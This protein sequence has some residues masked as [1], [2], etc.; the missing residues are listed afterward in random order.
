MRPR[1]SRGSLQPFEHF[2]RLGLDVHLQHLRRFHD[3]HE[4]VVVRCD[5]STDLDRLGHE[6]VREFIPD[7]VGRHRF[8]RGRDAGVEC[9]VQEGL[10]EFTV[11][12]RCHGP[13]TVVQDG[14][15]PQVGLPFDLAVQ[16]AGAFPEDPSAFRSKS[17][18]ALNWVLPVSS[19]RTPEKTA[20][21]FPS[22]S[23]SRRSTERTRAVTAT[24]E[25]PSRKS[26]TRTGVGL[27]TYGWPGPGLN[28]G[29]ES[30]ASFPTAVRTPK[31][32]WT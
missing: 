2:A 31:L 13:G 6:H 23:T 11:E 10:G 30:G 25:A 9:L 22:T 15:H 16:P 29:S 32:T 14:L 27:P 24:F 28:S 3:H 26:T 12:D 17:F 5:V 21:G 1:A 18:H 8:L 4:A 20:F 7:N 19:A